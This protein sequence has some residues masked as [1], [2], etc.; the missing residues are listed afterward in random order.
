MP[1]NRQHESERA[2]RKIVLGRKAWMFYGSDTHAEAAATL[3]SVIAS[4]RLHALGPFRYLEEM[5]RV[6]C[7]RDTVSRRPRCGRRRL[8]GSTHL[9]VTAQRL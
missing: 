2:L 9:I 8:L 5:L 4:C 7:D 1:R 3:F 6:S